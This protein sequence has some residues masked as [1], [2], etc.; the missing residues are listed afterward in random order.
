M[1]ELRAALAVNEV[2]KARMRAQ[3]SESLTQAVDPAQEAVNSSNEACGKQDI[4]TKY[5]VLSQLE[6]ANA[7]IKEL[8]HQLAEAL[9]NYE[10]SEEC[11][12]KP[13]DSEA[14]EQGQSYGE[15]VYQG[16]GQGLSGKE[17]W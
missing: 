8:E 3:F 15:E 4:R 14:Q 2:E 13:L 11:L 1:E 5:E 6:Q 10:V 9:P 12:S 16:E 7:K 17:A